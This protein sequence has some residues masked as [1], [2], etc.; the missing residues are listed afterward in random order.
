MRRLWQAFPV[1]LTLTTT[2]RPATDL[3]YLL[4]KN[5]AR[6]QSFSL[7]FGRAHVFYPEAAEDRCTAALLVEVDPVGLVRNRRGPAGEGG[8]L[9]QYVNDRP[10]AASSFLGVALAEVFGTA[11]SGACKERPELADQPLPLEATLPAVP[12]RSGEEFLR[13][14]FE[15][16]GYQIAAARLPLDAQFPEWGEGALHRVTLAATLPLHRLLSHLYVLVPVLDN[17]KHYWVGDDEVAKLLRHGEGWLAAHPARDLIARRYLKHRR[18]LVDDALEQLGEG[19]TAPD[20]AAAARDAEE[21][22][23]EA[24]VGQ[25][26]NLPTDRPAEV[27]PQLHEPMQPPVSSPGCEADGV[28]VGN[29]SHAV[30]EGSPPGTGTDGEAPSPGTPDARPETPPLHEQRLGAVLAVLKAGGAASV[31]DLGCGE[32]R[33][34][35]LLLRERQFTRILGLEV[36]HRALEMAA[37][38]LRYDRL[39]APQKERLK[40][41]HGSLM[42]RDARLAGFDAAAVVEVVEHLDPPRLAAFE[43]VLFEFARPGTVVL[44]TPNREYNVKWESLPAGR[45]RH[46]DHRFEWTRAEFRAWAEGVSA[47]FGYA[48]RFLPV[49][50]EDAAIGAPTQMGVFDRSA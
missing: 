15:P 31:L 26:G 45:F 24:R 42:Y 35:R 14:L 36:S 6:A 28:P 47:R 39:P 30:R 34:L 33:L 11:L 7:T 21:A 5:P 32:G 4:R 10:Y 44:T 46:R 2:H 43:R 49:G 20:E 8:L 40:L 9:D 29:R 12:V 19:D 41:L 16:L 25:V 27:E 3:G 17:D 22:A 37:D 18:G 38:K 50:P 1:L 23:L 13:R 48:V